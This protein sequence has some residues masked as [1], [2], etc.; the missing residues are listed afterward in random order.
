VAQS[1]GSGGQWR[2][3]LQRDRVSVLLIVAF[4]FGLV[5]AE[6]QELRAVREIRSSGAATSEPSRKIVSRLRVLMADFR[7]QGITNESA[8]ADVSRRFSSE[9][10][11][12]D[13]AGRVQVDVSVSDTSE[14][15][16][17]TLRGHGLDIE[18]VNHEFMR[19][20]GWVPVEKLEA[21][22]GE[23]AVK[24][25]RPPSYGRSRKGAARQTRIGSVNSQGD[26]IH[27]CDQARAMGYTG[28]GVKVGVVSDG[29]DG[30]AESQASG[31]LGPVEVLNAGSGDE[32]TAIL[33][34]IADCAPGAALAF[35]PGTTGLAFVNSVNALR[36]A[37]ASII[38]DDIGFFDEPFYE[39]GLVAL[40]DRAAGGAVLRVS[41]GG[42][43]ALGHYQATFSPGPFDV[44]AG[45]RHNFGGGD[46]RLR[47]LTLPGVSVI[48][49]VLQWANP[50][51]A[52][53]DD[54][55]LY[56]FQ[57]NTDELVTLSALVQN[58]NDDP[59]EPIV[60]G[61]ESDTGC[62]G[63]LQI[64]L[65]AGAAQPLK[66]FCVG[67]DL[68]EFNTPGGSIFGHPAVPEVLAVAAS[69]AG[70]PTTLQ[71]F[72]SRGDVTVLFPSPEVRSKPD[73]TGV[74]GVMT[75]RSG[76]TPFF[77]TSAAA[78]HV[79][80]VA[81][82]VAEANPS[83]A[84]GFPIPSLFFAN[85]MRGT[86]MDLGA[87]GRDTGFGF[88]LADAL[89]AVQTEEAKARCQILSSRSSVPVGQPF[90]VTVNTFPGAGDPWDIYVVGRV[91]VGESVTF[92]SLDLVS[93]TL[94]PV[95]L[96]RPARPTAPITESSQ[97]FGFIAPAVAQVEAFCA[98]VDPALTRINRLSSASIAFTP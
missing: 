55:D 75:S 28:A 32:G 7:V 10:L 9:F 52:A 36:A 85:A 65:F 70:A 53:A 29:V 97:S 72:S 79:A 86:A 77:G 74:D 96:I 3:I 63:D 50:F 64:S 62:V 8:P 18:I 33:E 81:A 54:Y 16:L 15:S 91:T 17:D 49:I 59:I 6:G 25:I 76:F 34:I 26:V 1:P 92:F 45:T 66:L 41:A 48:V 78:P 22:A 14:A 37:G 68:D 20:Q 60:F 21:L 93:G 23:A 12:V 40:N 89:T 19:V 82:L 39:D 27:R 4:I 90:T 46:T 2:V 31:N 24:R 13:K 11:K 88:G 98:F 51:G 71:P 69:P 5:H 80:G 58:G 87:E 35:S 30:L 83:Y 42:N 94:G 57:A 43:D 84:L 61:C 38:V 44:G 56:L 73:V 67:C 47:I 95:N